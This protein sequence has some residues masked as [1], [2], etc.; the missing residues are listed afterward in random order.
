MLTEEAIKRC[1]ELIKPVHSNW[2]GLTNQKAIEMILDIIEKYKNSDY[3]T[4]CLENSHLKEE[5]EKLQDE[6][7]E[8]KKSKYVYGIDMDFDYIPK[9]KIRDKIKDIEEDKENKYY[10]KFLEYRDLETTLEILEKLIG[11][12]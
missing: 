3:E 10:D 2:I 1:K 9:Q 8:L 7:K 6:N 12:K 11:E 4:I 5:L